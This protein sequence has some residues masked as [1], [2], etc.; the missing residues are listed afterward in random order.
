MNKNNNWRPDEAVDSLGIKYSGPILGGMVTARVA[1]VPSMRANP[2]D[3]FN[4]ER[5]TWAPDEQ[6]EFAPAR[7]DGVKPGTFANLDV[8][9]YAPRA[10]GDTHRR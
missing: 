1:L 7:V 6:E 9:I 3:P 5:K 4:V 2:L 8:S 10:G